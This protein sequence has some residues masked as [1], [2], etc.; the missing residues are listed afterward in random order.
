MLA[1]KGIEEGIYVAEQIAGQSSFINYDTLPSVI[2]TEPEIAWVGQTEQALKTMDIPIKVGVFPLNAT[3]RAQAIGQ[4]EGMIKII[5]H[6]E[7]DALLGVHIIGA[8]ASELIAEAVLAMEFSA[9]SED[10]ARTIHAH[11]TLSEGFHEAALALK[12]ISVHVPL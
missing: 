3:A 5:A 12:K 11:P 4:T 10:L 7:N 8:H 9:S 6:A 1:H 2:Y